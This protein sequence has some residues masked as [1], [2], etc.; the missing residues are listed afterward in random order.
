MKLFSIL[1]IIVVAAAHTSA[2]PASQEGKRVVAID[3]ETV[4]I[5]Y[6]TVLIT[7]SYAS[8]LGPCSLRAGGLLIIYTH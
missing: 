2:L 3:G 4:T 1:S 8:R 6:G 5:S 7:Y